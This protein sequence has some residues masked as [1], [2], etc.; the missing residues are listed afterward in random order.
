LSDVDAA[1]IAGFV[2]G[3]GCIM[4][5]MRR[6]VVAIRL[7]AVNTKLPVLEWIRDTTGVGC[8]SCKQWSNPRHAPSYTWVAQSEAAQTVIQQLLPY[9]RVKHAQA[10]LALEVLSLLSDPSFKADRSWQRPKRDEMRALNA[11]GPQLRLA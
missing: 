7:S 10:R 6:D 1:Y 5:E 4:A 11:R 2:D 9:L 8:I 3:E